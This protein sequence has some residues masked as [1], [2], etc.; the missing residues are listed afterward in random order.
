[1]QILQEFVPEETR[2]STARAAVWVQ[3]AKRVLVPTDATVTV[4]G[5]DTVVHVDYKRGRQGTV[6]VEKLS[7]TCQ[8]LLREARAKVSR[9]SKEAPKKTG[10]STVDPEE[11][12]ELAAKSSLEY[13]TALAVR[14][15]DCAKEHTLWA[16]STRNDSAEGIFVARGGRGAGG[17]GAG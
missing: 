9:D 13:H 14:Y 15:G 7:A 4:E 11:P 8:R 12:S 17:R 5:V 10:E 1:M 2:E 6:D 16:G 3:I